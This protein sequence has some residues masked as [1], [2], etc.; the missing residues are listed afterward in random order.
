MELDLR[1]RIATSK[2]Y[3]C[4]G[5][6]I[7]IKLSD[8]SLCDLIVRNK[9]DSF[10]FG[11]KV[12]GTTFT[13]TKEFNDYI[14]D[15]HHTSIQEFEFPLIV[16]CVNINSEEVRIGMLSRIRFDEFIV[17]RNP[18]LVILNERNASIL[19]DNV[20]SL[21]NII[22]VLHND[23]WGIVKD[24]KITRKIKHVEI[25]AHIIYLRTLNDNYK[26]KRPTLEFQKSKF[27]RYMFGLDEQ[28]YPQDLLDEIILKGV[29]NFYYD[30]EVSVKSSMLLF[31]TELR[32]L[33]NVISSYQHPK[34]ISF[35]I[36]P[37]IDKEIMHM[38]F[39]TSYEFSLN[40]YTGN[41][42]F[43]NLWNDERIVI[44]LSNHEWK[45]FSENSIM[46]TSI[47][48]VSSILM[49]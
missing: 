34:E 26:F 43:I 28:E 21:D 12:G 46:R 15:L 5:E 3:K 1:L 31:N 24:I 13:A 2:L 40:L 29:T 19:Y 7:A 41:N 38:G 14:N 18:Q 33:K 16:A 25:D 23:N 4:F 39:F 49:R 10:S 35:L 45:S 30:S 47:K 37:D 22:R 6:D 27:E 17:Y 9:K 32:D 44:S 36:E 48:K 8:N 11:V 20:N 42:L